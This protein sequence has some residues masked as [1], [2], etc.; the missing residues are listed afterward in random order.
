MKT[1]TF[2][3]ITSI[4]QAF[5]IITGLIT[6]LIEKWGRRWRRRKNRIYELLEE[7]DERM[8]EHEMATREQMDKMVKAIMDLTKK[9]GNLEYSN[10][11]VK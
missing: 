1:E 11:T 6:V 8:H 5:L 3:L 4:V 10:R 9:V 2:L 7:H